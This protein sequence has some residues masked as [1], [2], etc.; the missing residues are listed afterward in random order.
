M[1]GAVVVSESRLARSKKLSPT[2]KIAVR[3]TTFFSTTLM[4]TSASQKAETIEAIA[5]VA[6]GTRKQPLNMSPRLHNVL[7]LEH[8]RKT[9][10]AKIS[11]NGRYNLL[12]QPK[13]ENLDTKYPN[14]HLI[15]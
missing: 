3:I 15:N 1:T 6:K 8:L 7:T 11:G 2:S 4:P 14:K 9:R 12:R 13:V 5:K 10:V